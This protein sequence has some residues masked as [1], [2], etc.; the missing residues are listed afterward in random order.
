MS[1]KYDI[2]V[3]IPVYKPINKLKSY[4][5]LSISNTIKVLGENHP[6]YL[7]HPDHLAIDQ[8]S[9]HF[10]Y[11]FH[12]KAFDDKYFTDQLGYNRLC[13]TR[14]FYE[15]WSN[16]SYMMIIQT[17]AY[18]FR[19]EIAYF[20]KY[21]YVGAP[22]PVSP[23]VFY[24]TTGVPAVGN[25]GFSLRKISSVIEILSSNKKL[26]RFDEM[27]RM[28]FI[29][30]TKKRNLK[31]LSKYQ[32]AIYFAQTV[33]I[34][35]FLNAFNKAYKMDYF[36]EDVLLGIFGGAIFEEFHV[37]PVEEAVKFAFEQNPSEMFASTKQTLPMGCH[38]FNCHN[39]EFWK[40]HIPNLHID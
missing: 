36:F 15:S 39:P 23:V 34:Y 40:K 26:L 22:W 13:L 6:I 3:V 21:D 9:T 12:H 2:V 33:Y 25:G 16:F 28:I 20:T 5:T 17:D 38:A 24:S 27:L 31:Q 30:Q 7:I 4:E 8:Y 29:H 18:I 14:S 11:P 35:L 32:K 37:A 1:N 19:D 10:N